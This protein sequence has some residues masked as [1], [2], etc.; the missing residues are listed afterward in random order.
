MPGV[1]RRTGYT[2][3]R[4]HLGLVPRP[5]VLQSSPAEA[6]VHGLEAT[7][8]GLEATVHGLEATVHGLESFSLFFRAGGR[9]KANYVSVV[10]CE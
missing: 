4:P 6:T 10:Y 7:V 2:R 9:G 3:Y 5:K 1:A 8:H